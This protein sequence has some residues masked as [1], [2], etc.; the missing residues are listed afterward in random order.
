MAGA[1]S[2]IYGFSHKLYKVE[3]VDLTFLK[4]MKNMSE[5]KTFCVI[6]GDIRFNRLVNMLASNGNLVYAIGLKDSIDVSEYVRLEE[7]PKALKMADV[8]ILP[9]PV[10]FDGVFVNASENILLSDIFKLIPKQSVVLGG[11]VSKDVERIANEYNV[12]IIDYLK[13]EEMAVQNAVP[14]AEGAIEIAM[15]EMPK[16]IFESKC[17]VTGYG[18]ISKVLAHILKSMGAKVDVCAR[19]YSD[20]SWANIF[21]CGS[22]HI[23]QL[24]QKSYE[25]DVIFNTVP[26]LIIDEKILKTLDKT[27]I[28]DLASQPGGVDFKIAEKLGVKTIW[29]LSLPGKVAPDTA[30]DII[31]NTVLNIIRERGEENE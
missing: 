9:L 30:G 24:A 18:R 26:S 13:R 5:N 23:S 7:I 15:R 25:Y 14:T 1:L 19:K 16:T 10:S 3:L 11:K 22:F 6:G 29:A 2:L 4:G 20:L 21:G 12:A 27:F 28:I 8:V 31:L 17:L